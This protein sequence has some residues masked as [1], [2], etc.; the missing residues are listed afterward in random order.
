[1]LQGLPDVWQESLP[2]DDILNT[3]YINPHLVPSPASKSM[4]H[5]R[6]FCIINIIIAHQL[7]IF[8]SGPPRT[9]SNQAADRIGTPFNVQHNVHVQVDQSR[10]GFTVSNYCAVIS[11]NTLYLT[12][13]IFRVCHLD[14]QKF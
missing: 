12:H 6:S 3:T 11:S 13:A 7:Y 8:A 14:G 10:V 1:M 5:Y 9:T 2:S 4:C